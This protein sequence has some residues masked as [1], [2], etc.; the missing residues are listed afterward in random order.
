MENSVALRIR[1]Y[2]LVGAVI[3]VFIAMAP[4]QQS[5]NYSRVTEDLVENIVIMPG[6]FVTN[7]VIGGFR[8]LAADILW[9][10]MDECWHNGKWF[11]LLPILRAVTWMQPHFIE[12]WEIGGWH[13]A[14]NLYAY[15]ANSPDR[16]RYIEDGIRFLKEGLA[17]NRNVYNLWFNLGWIYYHKLAD[18][19][20]AIRYFRSATRYEHPD[21]IDRLIAHAY[22]KKGDIAS[23]YKEWLRCETLYKDNR[24]HVGIVEKHLQKAR[25]KL[26]QNGTLEGVEAP[27]DR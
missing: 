20:E 3:F 10:K 2:F 17:R 21:Y 7:F 18:Y 16:E 19:D 1:K 11:E 14:Y 12:A 27:S 23:E 13:L 15:A 4:L 5:I 24:H 9:L 26:I 22:R 25:D 6:E 8:G